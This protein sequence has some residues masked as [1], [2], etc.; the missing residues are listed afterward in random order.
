MR[1]W[2]IQRAGGDEFSGCRG[3][4]EKR[5]FATN[6]NV[7]EGHAFQLFRLYNKRRGIET[8]YLVKNI[9]RT[10]TTLKNYPGR[11]F[12][13]LFSVCLY[14]LWVLVNAFVGAFVFERL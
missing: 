5:V 1:K 7:T 10:R 12:F 14:N 4:G 3:R 11:L 9:F 13:F 2:Q 6:I 8:G